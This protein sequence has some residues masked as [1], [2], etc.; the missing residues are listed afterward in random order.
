MQAAGTHARRMTI[1]EA[2]RSLI[3]GDPS[4]LL[5]RRGPGPG[6]AIAGGAIEVTAITVHPVI[7]RRGDRVHRPI[8]VRYSVAGR[9][10]TV[11]LWLKAR[12]GIAVLLSTLEAYS[13]RLGDEIFP[14]PLYAW[15]SETGDESFLIT[16]RVGGEPLR[17]RLVKAALV[18]AALGIP[19]VVSDDIETHRALYPQTSVRWYDVASLQINLESQTKWSPLLTRRRVA[20]LWQAFWNGYRGGDGGG[21]AATAID[22]LANERIPALLYAIRVQYLL[23]GTARVPLYR[24]FGGMLGRRYV[25]A[26]VRGLVAGDDAI[27]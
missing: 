13:E 9:A 12:P 16:E 21:A 1:E 23:G 4:R 3:L 5:P 8:T 27:S 14:R 25:R 18:C 7:A 19:L 15:T 11:E 22:G 24:M 20:P 10:G 6:S 17:D 26:L 2:A